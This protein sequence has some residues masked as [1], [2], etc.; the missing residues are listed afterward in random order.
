MF[1]ES[2]IPNIQKVPRR[3]G[4]TLRESIIGELRLRDQQ[5][6]LTKIDI[7]RIDTGGEDSGINKK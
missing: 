1:L 7:I 3:P 6:A 2:R 5:A 4:I